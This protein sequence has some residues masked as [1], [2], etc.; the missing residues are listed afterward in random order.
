MGPFQNKE[1]FS[2]RLRLIL[3]RLE[4]GRLKVL[5]GKDPE[6]LHDFRVSLRRLRT[7]LRLL[8]SCYPH[9]SLEPVKA[10]LKG[11]A[12]T[13]NSLRDLEV[14]GELWKSLPPLPRVS[15]GLEEWLK[16]QEEIRRMREKEVREYLRATPLVRRLS[17]LGPKL[18]LRANGA[19]AACLAAEAFS[20]EREK[21][22]G[23]LRKTRGPKTGPALLHKLRVQ[24]KRVRYSLEEFA[25]LLPGRGQDLA[26][27]CKKAQNA[28]GD[29][30]D[31]ESAL[32]LLEKAGNG[33]FPEIR[34]W[35]EELRNRRK[36]ARK[37]SQKAVRTLRKGLG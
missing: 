33:L 34:P 3:A 37:E 25:F 35:R 22:S 30:R 32:R 13:T 29:W 6:A 21:L 36:A 19:K 4:R 15:S 8:E 7:C 11:A 23:L 27:A 20:R 2:K 18:D 24:A 9:R 12:Q 31:T 10:L 17:A 1:F 16:T 28:L 26:S 14:S 5:Q